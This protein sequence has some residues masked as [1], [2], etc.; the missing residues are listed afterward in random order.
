MPSK[1]RIARYI[2]NAMW[3]KTKVH[4]VL[5][6]RPIVEMIIYVPIGVLEEEDYIGGLAF[7]IKQLGDSRSR[8][9]SYH[10]VVSSFA[11]IV[12]DAFV[13]ACQHLV[14]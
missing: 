1:N 9:Y 14:I 7:E 2:M 11:P 13:D 10:A 6:R 3:K 5:S 12:L 8:S 4:C